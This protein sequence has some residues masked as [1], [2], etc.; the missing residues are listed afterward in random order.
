MPLRTYR[1][2]R[3]LILTGLQPGDSVLQWIM[4]RLNGLL[5]ALFAFFGRT[6]M[7]VKA[8]TVETVLPKQ[9]R[10]SPG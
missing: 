2:V 10:S 5:I 8:E 4:N 7:L 9:L 3:P 6:L 1:V